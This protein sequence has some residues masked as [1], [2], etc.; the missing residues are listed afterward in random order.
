MPD[1]VTTFAPLPSNRRAGAFERR[2]RRALGRVEDGVRVVVAAS[3]GADSMAAL[4][5]VARGLGA[6]CVTAAHFDH[7]LRSPDEARHDR[8]TVEGV[9][10]RLGVPLVTG[11]AARRPDDH[12]EAAAREARYRWLARACREAGATV[13]VTGHTLDDQAETVLLRLVRGSGA[14]GAAG[15]REE[16]PWPVHV[17]GAGTLRLRR[18]LLGVTRVEV[19]AYVRALGLEV[20]EDASNATLDYARNRV[21]HAVLPALR[22][23]NLRAAEHL[24]AFASSQREDDDALTALARDWL[25]RTGESETGE[26]E[27]GERGVGEASAGGVESVSVLLGP[28]RSL[29]PA[30]QARVVREA[31][32]R[33]GVPLEAAHV[34][35][36]LGT[37]GRR[38]ARVDL[39]DALSRTSRTH[40][41]LR[42]IQQDQGDQRSEQTLDKLGQPR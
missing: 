24:A 32:R 15:M 10:A 39:P 30:L 12:S 14:L 7:R 2:V 21:R 20:S 29:P 6:G 25:A 38:G 33:I 18:P 1:H 36:I 41:E 35:A 34:Q 9:A 16:A 37:L 13:C 31:A 26:R 4:V 5:A 40:L 19:E 3:G 22:E 42:R 27:A 17:R 23:L 8:E 11:R 28:L